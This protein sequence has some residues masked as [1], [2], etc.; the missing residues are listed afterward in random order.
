MATSSPTTSILQFALMNSGKVPCY[1]GQLLTPIILTTLAPI[2][3]EGEIRLA[4]AKFN[5]KYQVL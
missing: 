3:K 1:L 4:Q 2:L 5:R